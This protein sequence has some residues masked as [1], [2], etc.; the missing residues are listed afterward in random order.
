MVHHASLTWQT[1]LG[2]AAAHSKALTCFE[3]HTGLR[4]TATHLA[5]AAALACAWQARHGLLADVAHAF[6]RYA[7]R[8]LAATAAAFDAVLGVR[9][10]EAAPGARGLAHH[11]VAAGIQR[12]AAAQLLPRAVDGLVAAGQRARLSVRASLKLR[13]QG[14][15]LVVFGRRHRR[16]AIRRLAQAAGFLAG[17][18]RQVAAG[19]ARRISAKLDGLRR[20]DASI[21]DG[22][23]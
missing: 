7:H 9:T 19:E 17:P 6:A 12:T 13:R 3:R 14:C 18:T 16:H 2:L 22:G 11:T 4:I 1:I 21:G 23:S 8:A 10:V 20:W 5:L 15:D